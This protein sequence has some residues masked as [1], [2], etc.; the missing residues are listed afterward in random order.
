MNGMNVADAAS[1]G[2]DAN[3]TR[4]ILSQKRNTNLRVR[5]AMNFEHC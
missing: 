5:E 4:H 3:S 2:V 1:V